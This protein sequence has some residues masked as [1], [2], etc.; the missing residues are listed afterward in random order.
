MKWERPSPLSV[1]SKSIF[2]CGGSARLHPGVCENQ[3]FHVRTA[4]PHG[5]IDYPMPS[6]YIARMHKKTPKKNKIKKTLTQTLESP[7]VV[8]PT[9]HPAAATRRRRYRHAAAAVPGPCPRAHP[10]PP[11][12][13]RMPPLPDPGGGRPLPPDPGRVRLPS[14]LATATN[15]RC[16]SQARRSQLPP[17]SPLAT[18]T[19]APDTTATRSAR[20]RVGDSHRR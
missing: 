7:P 13:C 10:P 5:I 8:T 18:A 9:L 3:Y 6:S 4:Q 11:P 15:C 12:L 17:S 2:P 19:V 20:I 1:R 16:R 14:H